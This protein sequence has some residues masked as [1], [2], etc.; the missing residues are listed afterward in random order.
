MFNI[1]PQPNQIIISKGKPSFSLS[2]DT[3]VTRT[4]FTTEFRDFVKK[5]F[6]IR[7]HR[8]I[9]DDVSIKLVKSSEIAGEEGYTLISRDGR[10]YIYGKNECG[11]F[12]GLQTLKQLLLQ[13]DGTV[14]DMY[15]EDKP[16]YPYRGFMLDSSRRFWRTSEIKR[17][18]D[19]MALHKLNVFHW[20]LTDDQGWRIEIGKYPMLTQ[21]G[22]HRRRR[23][24]KTNDGKRYYTKEQI[25]DIVEYCRKRFIKVI[26][27]FDVPGHTVAA[28]ASYPELSCFGQKRNVASSWGVK[29][30]ILCAGKDSTLKFVYEVTDE[31]MQLFP[32]K[33]IH[34]GGDD[35]V[36]MRWSICPHCQKRIK[37]ES[38]KDEQELYT[39][40]MNK[41][42]SHIEKN[43]GKAIIRGCDGSDKEKP[44]DKNI[45]WQVCD[46]DMNGKVVSREGKTGRAFINSSSPH[47]YLNL[48]YS[49]INL[50]KTYEYAPEPVYGELLG[51][52]AVIWTEHISSIKSLDFMV[53]PRIAAIAEIAWSDK[54]DRSY[55]RF[56]NSL[57]EYYDLLNIYEVRYA[58]L[59]QANPSKLRKAAYGVAWR[60]K[61]VNFHRL[62]DLAE[63]EKSRSLAKKENR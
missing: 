38:L 63:D 45:I 51:T 57:P 48:P 49:M 61:T 59:K 44:L 23:D 53:F 7:I 9:S 6:D 21:K 50:K 36:K 35:A 55:E 5:Q 27:E 62:Y 41:I 39:W 32:D 31:I 47:Y 3:T 18:I 12:Y 58:T 1:I 34:I 46:K 2:P 19:L 30:D 28:I 60:N 33:I 4:D 43:G 8:E 16:L 11:I 14:P 52:E 37:D 20:H 10:I 25:R 17:L 24:R 42:A 54:D 22:S 15:I 56:L 13:G 40:F 26:P 29:H